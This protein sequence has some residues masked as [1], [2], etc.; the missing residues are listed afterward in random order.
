MAFVLERAY[1]KAGKW[2][3]KTYG[4]Y[5]LKNLKKTSKV[6]NLGFSKFW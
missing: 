2:L 3:R 5:V 1:S 4:F 6:P